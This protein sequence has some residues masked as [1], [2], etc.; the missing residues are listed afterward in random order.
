[1]TV[2][3]PTTGTARAA[4]LP[5]LSRR[6]FLAGAGMAG[7][8][9]LAA[10]SLLP[11]YAFATPTDPAVGDVLVVVFL[12]GGADGLSLV[13]PYS[14]SGYRTLRGFGT[15]NSIA[16][17]APPASGTNAHAALPLGVTKSGHEFG[18]H[19]AMGA[20]KGVWDAGDLAIVHA[21][22]M[23]ASA[24]AT[25]SHFEAQ[26]NWERGTAV[27]STASGWVARH[28]TSMGTL[29]DIPGV[30][31]A[32]GLAASMRGHPRALSLSSIEGF[33]LG[34]YGSG[35]RARATEVLRAAWPS[36]SSDSVI[37]AGREVLDA[38]G[39][40]QT[41]NPEQHAPNPDPYP[42]EW[43]AAPY[44]DAFREVAM[45]IRAGIGLRAVCL[46]LGDGVW[47][48]HDNMGPPGW[49]S[50]R[51]PVTVLS[52]CLAAFHADLARP[53]VAGQ[54]AT[55]PINEVTTV[56]MSEF[57]RT[58]NVNG[59]NGTDHGRGSVMFVM[60]GNVT[61]GI[62]GGYP[63]G[64]LVDGPEGDLTVANDFRAV[65][66]EVLADRCGNTSGI[67]TVFPGWSGSHL[68]VCS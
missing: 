18:F 59:S 41:R 5:A 45:L 65:L 37:R 66:A 22:G 12:R 55:A 27:E 68:G 13:A 1:M 10:P 11:R 3:A 46:D 57:G 25:R 48:T 64:P 35:D 62:H 33:G 23:P 32:P 20:L 29:P 56:T 43:P 2:T 7:L 6:S 49:G 60:G 54:P 53:Q 16:V 34:G 47:D 19:P 42:T 38:I 40:V 61:K 51:T 9:G 36:G 26:A 28:L 67:G 39:L 31:Y 4:T 58:V 50:F 17:E 44:A 30:S 63:S 8:V 14:D 15:S 21:V 24:S 52:E